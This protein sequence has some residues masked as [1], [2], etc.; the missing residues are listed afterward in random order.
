MGP[1][2]TGYAVGR[3]LPSINM[4]TTGVT[5][6]TNRILMVLRPTCR[7]LP[8]INMVTTWVT[9]RTNRVLMVLGPT[10]VAAARGLTRKEIL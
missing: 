8:S 9:R 10:Q 3:P 6:R 1:L 2:I 4:V 7:S 5:S